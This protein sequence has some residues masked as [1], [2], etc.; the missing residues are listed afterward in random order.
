L[1]AC[2][3]G[4]ARHKGFGLVDARPKSASGET[5]AGFVI[6]TQLE[7]IMMRMKQ[8]LL[9]LAATGMLAGPALAAEGLGAEAPSALALQPVQAV[10]V[11]ELVAE[12]HAPP[13][14]AELPAQA[15]AGTL[16]AELPELPAV[17]ALTPPEPF[18]AAD[19]QALFVPGHEP[20]RVAVLSPQEMEET[21]GAFLWFAPIVLHAGRFAAVRIAHHSA[22]HSFGSLGRLPH[23]QFNAW[24]PG[25]SGSGGAFRIPLPNT[26]FFRP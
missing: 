19:M 3:A 24:R 5:E 20:L 18:S 17:L 1:W 9:A 13:A 14:Q 25:V 22:H 6:E 8:T 7:Y 12:L 15:V 10:A 23:I 11:A 4:S 21:K 2:A 16:P 26:P